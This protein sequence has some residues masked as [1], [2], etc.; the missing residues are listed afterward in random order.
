MIF[1]TKITSIG[2][3]LSDIGCFYRGLKNEW[4]KQE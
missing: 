3:V 1:F 4:Q 2:I